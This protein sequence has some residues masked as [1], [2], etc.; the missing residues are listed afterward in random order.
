MK[1]ELIL[2][3]V[4]NMFHSLLPMY[5]NDGFL[6]SMLTPVIKAKKGA[7]KLQFYS[8]KDYEK[9]KETAGNVAY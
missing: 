7:Q 6:N 4:F 8:V 5:K 1:M 9:W 2:R 3:V